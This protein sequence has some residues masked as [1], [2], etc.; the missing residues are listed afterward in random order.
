ML[1]FVIFALKLEFIRPKPYY[2][3]ISQDCIEKLVECM[4]G[5]DIEEM[6]CETCL[7]IQE[8]LCDEIDDEEFLNFAIDNLE[9]LCSYIING[10]LTIKTHRDITCLPYVFSRPNVPFGTGRLAGEMWFEVDVFYHSFLE[11][12]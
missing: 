3:Q 7:K 11:L 6:D 8:I 1:C 5:I 2:H 9:E 4:K 12:L 10:N